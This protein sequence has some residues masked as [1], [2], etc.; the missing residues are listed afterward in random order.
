M[1]KRRPI[2][3]T[4]RVLLFVSLVIGLG[5][6]L[7]ASLIMRSIEHHFAE[8]DAGELNAIVHVIS[9][10]LQQHGADGDFLSAELPA[11]VAGHHGTRFE[12]RDMNGRLLAPASDDGFATAAALLDPAAG[13]TAATLHVWQQGDQTFRGVVTRVQTEEGL[14]RVT[15]AINMGFH[16]QFLRSFRDSLW[17]ILL[18]TGVLTLL[19]AA[20]AVYQGHLPLRG[21]SRSMQQIQTSNLDVRIDP[22]TLPSELH[23]LANSFNTMLARL[24]QGFEQ[25]THFSSDIAHELRT[26]LTS[27]MTQIQVTLSKP[28]DAGTYRELMYSSLEELERL[29]KMVADMLWLAKSDNQLI[30]P[31]LHALNMKD[32]IQDLFEF[33]EALAAEKNIRLQQQGQVPAIRADRALL[34]RALSNLLSNALRYT[35]AG[36]YVSVQLSEEHGRVLIRV[37]NPGDT[38]AAQHLPRLFDRFYRADPARSRQ[39]EGAGLGLA[40]TRSIIRAHGGDIRASSAD[41]LTCFTIELPAAGRPPESGQ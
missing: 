13:V 12:I 18:V 40:I 5:F 31:Q 17:L 8:Q 3:L 37:S 7:I 35:P 21:L 36:E 24:Q 39:S 28:R 29:S 10:A 14:Y 19:A 6:L 27:L 32:E 11:L 23:G 16:L 34:R 22:Y 15:A 38:I 30:Q 20:F 1:I 26:P 41:G 25:L 9:D 2:S 4:L 33:F